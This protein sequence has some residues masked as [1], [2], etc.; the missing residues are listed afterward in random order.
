MRRHSQGR[1]AKDDVCLNKSSGA[2]GGPGG[3]KAVSTMA[4]SGPGGATHRSRKQAIFSARTMT[5]APD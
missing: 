2:R 1:L 5:F 4:Y 3:P